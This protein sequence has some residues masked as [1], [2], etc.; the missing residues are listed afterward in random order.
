MN[1][2]ERAELKFIATLRCFHGSQINLANG[3][4]SVQ[5]VQIPSSSC[6]LPILAS[7]VTP[8]VIAS[9]SDLQFDLFCSTTG[10]CKAG[11]MSKADV[12]INGIS[13]SLKFTNSAPPAIVNHTNRTGWQFAALQKGLNM[14]PIDALI[15]DYWNKRVSGVIKED[16]DNLHPLSP[17]ASHMHTLLPFL[18]YFSFEGTGSRLSNHPATAV[19]E[20]SDPCNVSTW[21]II[22]QPQFISSIWSRLVFS[23]R[24]SKGMPKDINSVGANSRNS[25]MMWSRTQNG[26]LKGAL[27]VRV[28]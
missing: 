24:S 26:S 19:I 12:F 28:R 1:A 8:Q 13:Y 17:F 3:P 4:L 21:K 10:I 16:V 6:L 23:L 11:T 25:I 27:H 5:S 2:G 9:M 7:S 22:N 18:E 15:N 20:F 14:A